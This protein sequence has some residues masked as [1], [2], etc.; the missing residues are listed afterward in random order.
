MLMAAFKPRFHCFRL[1]SAHG[2]HTERVAICALRAIFIF[3]VHSLGSPVAKVTLDDDQVFL[4]VLHAYSSVGYP[5]ARERL[6]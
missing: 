1:L 6:L 4:Y 2:T 5:V 3:V